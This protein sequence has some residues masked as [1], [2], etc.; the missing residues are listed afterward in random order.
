MSDRDE[1]PMF[2]AMPDHLL[3]IYD[4]FGRRA[5]ALANDVATVLQRGRA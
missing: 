2:S 5:F 3:P 4:V 1:R